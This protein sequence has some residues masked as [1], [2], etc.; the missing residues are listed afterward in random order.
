MEPDR[1]HALRWG[2]YASAIARW[3][4][5]VGREAPAPALLSDVS[6]LRPAPAFVEWLM[7]LDPGW[8]TESVSQI[9]LNQQLASLGNGV[10]PLQAVRALRLLRMLGR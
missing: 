10:L 7:G 2:R 5:V 3:E 6:G 4:H 1:R 8:V 9:T